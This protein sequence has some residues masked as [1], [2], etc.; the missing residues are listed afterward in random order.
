M[1]RADLRWMAVC[2]A[3]LVLT[4]CSKDGDV[5]ALER[6]MGP[7]GGASGTELAAEQVLHIGNG[8]EPHS[9]DPQRG[10]DTSGSF[11]QYDLFEGLVSQ[12]EHGDIVPG[13]AKSWEASDDG[14]T[15]TFHL[16]DNARWSNGEPVTAGDFVFS[17][18]R[19][20]DP[21]TLSRYT[22]IVS[23]ILNADD[24]AAGKRPTT[25]LGVRAID[26][27][28]LEIRL[29]NPTPYFIGLLN[30][31][32]TYPV[33]PRNVEKYGDQFTRPGKLVSNGAY[34]LAEWVV[35]AHI[36]VVRNPYYWDN[37]HTTVDA[38]WFYATEDQEAELKRYR[39]GE[40]DWSY[41][42]PSKQLK[43]IRENLPDQFHT[44]PYLGSYYYAYNVTRPPF[45][46]AP[47]LRRALSLAI[48]RDIITKKLLGGGQI[49]AYG[50]V[51]PVAH[52]A[53]QQMPEAKLTQAEREAEAKRLYAEAGYSAEHPLHTEIMY[54]TE[55]DHR[56]IAIAIASMWKQVLGVETTITNQEW[57]VFIETRR[58]KVDT[59]VVRE[60]WIG[61]YDD[62]N[63]FADVFL[64]TSQ[65]ND[66]GYVNPVYDSLVAQ[67]AAERDLDKRAELL[68]AAE[69]QL[70]E[71]MPMI[72][73]YFY[74]SQH[75][76]Q[77][78][79]KGWDGN[80]LDQHRHKYFYVLKH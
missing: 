40:L 10:E 16:R 50:W 22:F 43:W 72:P 46:D 59:Q 57:K 5:D 61:D 69:R 70:L 71:D 76:I 33:N 65:M 63:T 18:R 75:M 56:R 28:T 26:D 36:K 74:V 20:V 31:P 6:H 67:A 51:P 1:M 60:G 49:S 45:K 9:I 62:A 77:P 15:Y 4:A 53:D 34:Q 73:L 21:K 11:I 19:A 42:I 80:I 47:K 23:P 52:Y 32:V 2:L 24:I 44:A 29:G 48:N 7:I 17:L 30:H 8:A 38:V 54:N 78:W 14:L 37:A 41:T 35:Q 64:S 66:A 79:V 68:E 27:H 3:G 55:A 12:N 39:A 58:L 25:D 13:V